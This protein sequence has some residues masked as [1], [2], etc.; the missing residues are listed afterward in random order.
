MSGRNRT[1][2]KWVISHERGR[3]VEEPAGR[4]RSLARRED[5]LTGKDPSAAKRRGGEMFAPITEGL[6]LGGLLSGLEMQGEMSDLLEEI[7]YESLR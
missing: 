6:L 4:F 5:T 1:S 7:Y 2:R 3:D